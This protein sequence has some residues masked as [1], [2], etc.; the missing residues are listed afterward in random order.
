[1]GIFLHFTEITLTTRIQNLAGTQ[2]EK[3]TNLKPIT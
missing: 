3:N 2:K 1:M